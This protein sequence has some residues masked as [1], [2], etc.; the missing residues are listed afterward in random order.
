[1]FSRPTERTYAS[2]SACAFTGL[3]ST[4]YLFIYSTNTEI[5]LFAILNGR[6][7]QRKA[8]V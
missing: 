4:I 1:M 6:G 8:S 3:L 7:P 2:L 5:G